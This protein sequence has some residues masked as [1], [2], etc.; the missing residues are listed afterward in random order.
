MICHGADKFLTNL[1]L[2]I[3]V[4]VRLT[5]THDKDFR[6]RVCPV[7]LHIFLAALDVNAA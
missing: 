5:L 3:L 7:L 6:R 1:F 4:T 2:E